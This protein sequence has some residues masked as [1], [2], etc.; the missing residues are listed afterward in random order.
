MGNLVAY[1][2]LRVGLDLVQS[3]IAIKEGRALI[4]NNFELLYGRNGFKRVDGYERFDGRPLASTA[5]YF[6][7][8]VSIT[9]IPVAGDAVIL[10]TVSALVVEYVPNKLVVCYANDAI[11]ATGDVLVNGT[12]VGTITGTAIKG[13]IDDNNYVARRNTAFDVV[14][15]LTQPLNG[16]GAIL[17][18]AIYGDK[19]I[20][21][22]NEADGKTASIYESS[23]GGWVKKQGGLLPNGVWRFARNNFL[24]TARTMALYCVDG[25]NNM[26]QYLNGTVTQVDPIFGSQATSTTSLTP[27]TGSKTLTLT[28]DTVRSWA[29]GDR[30]IAY[31]KANAAIFMK[32][33]VTAFTTTAPFTV[34][35][36][37]DAI[38][39]ATA[40]ADWQVG[41]ED[42]RDKPYMVMAHKDHLFLAY[43]NGQLQHSDLGEPMKYGVDGTAGLF[44]IGDEITGM[45]SLK[46]GVLGVFCRNR[47]YTLYGSSTAD[48][49]LDTFSPSSGCLIDTLGET[50]GDAIFFDDVGITNMQAVNAFGDFSSA[51]ISR[52]IKPIIDRVSPSFALMCKSKSQYRVFTGGGTGIIAT[53]LG[54]ANNAMQVGFSQ[55]QYAH[56]F[57]CGVSG[58][59]NGEE[60]MLAGTDDGYVMRLDS[61]YSFDGQIVMAVMRLHYQ[62]YKSFS[63][64]KRFKKLTLELDAPE[65][66]FIKTKQQFDG[67]SGDYQSGIYQE[68]ETLHKGGLLEDASWSEFIWSQPAIGGVEAYISGVGRDMSLLVV[69]EGVEVPYLLQGFATHYSP[70]GLKR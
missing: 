70:L 6:R 9:T 38:G 47:I 16:S 69:S 52:D 31:S 62:N 10:G 43:Q 54:V 13:A 60:W 23:T 11:P 68:I 58:E 45:V 66:V 35:I 44:G 33:A 12:N 17:G 42:Y 27:A 20:A 4:L 49:R 1:T 19:V 24:G 8:P 39:D 40:A 37:V 36:N 26:M 2:P 53:M 7:V 56:N 57:T 5:K 28:Q 65:P 3:P 46:G 41:Y 48:W 14:R 30:L 25:R 32:G 61:G 67:L 21:V 50:V 63:Q 51:V 22:R 55:F 15:G 34:T 18:V 59:V 64:K 29:V